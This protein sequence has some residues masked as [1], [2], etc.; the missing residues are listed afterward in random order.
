MGNIL[1]FNA[2]QWFDEK[3]VSNGVIPFRENIYSAGGW[4]DLHPVLVLKASGCDEVVFVT[5]QGGESVFGQQVFIRLTG[6]TDKIRFWKEIKSQ[7]R[8]GWKDLTQVEQNSPWNRLYNLGN[9]DSSYNVSVNEADAVYCTDWDKYYIFKDDNIKDTL[10]DSWDAPIFL[11][12]ESRRADYN[13]GVD[14]TGR[15]KDNFPG[16]IPR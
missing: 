11:K 14:P 12:D 1:T 4:P 2:I 15:S 16:C 7:N 9:P 8:V 3:N 10:T 13:F 5:R 6:Y